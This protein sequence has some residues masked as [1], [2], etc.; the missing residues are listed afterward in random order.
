MPDHGS[1]AVALSRG[2]VETFLNRIVY[3]E[4]NG[5][6]SPTGGT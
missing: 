4:A 5:H 6:L 3:L 2:D 1:D